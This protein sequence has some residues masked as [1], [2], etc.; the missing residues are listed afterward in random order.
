MTREQIPQRD[1]ARE[2]MIYASLTGATDVTNL[3]GQGLVDAAVSKSGPALGAVGIPAPE[4][5]AKIE[6]SAFGPDVTVGGEV[7]HT[8]FVSNDNDFLSEVPFGDGTID[9][10]NQLFVFGSPTP[11]WR[12]LGLTILTPRKSPSFQSPPPGRR[13][14]WASSGSASWRLCA[15]E[16]P[17]AWAELLLEPPAFRQ[18]RWR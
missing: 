2:G 5:P 3:S 14:F 10:P 15:G 8:L 18:N 16:K 9:N 11:I 4:V 7:E 17:C 13:W 6:G 1:S 12:S